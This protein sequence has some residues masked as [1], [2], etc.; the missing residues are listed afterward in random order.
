MSSFYE[1]YH[2]SFVKTKS[3]NKI[4][5]EKNFTYFNFFRFV[6]PAIRRENPKNILDVGSGA[7]TIGLYLS[8]LGFKV[9]G[10][11]ISKHAVKQANASA[12]RLGVQS[13]SE[14]INIDFLRFS[15]NEKFDVIICLE[16]I[17]H[18]KND[19]FVL[20]KLK[21]RLVPNGLLV[22]STPLKSAPL[23]RIGLTRKFDR[24]VGHIR[25]YSESE[26]KVQIEN[27]GFSITKVVKTEGIIRNSLYILSPFGFIIKFI[28]GYITDIVTFLDDISG[29]LFGYSDI[30]ILAR[31]K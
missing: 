26:I 25:R 24:N 12:K 8:S 2:K 31:K 19:D 15:R 5:E 16:V 21:E 7:G 1:N 23:M 18:L 27:V 6:L 10:L 29:Q 22:L 9:V 30:I 4:I 14:Y 11:D 17:E 3:Q 28:K 13:K 20:K